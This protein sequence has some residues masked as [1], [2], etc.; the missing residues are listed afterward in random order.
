LDIGEAIGRIEKAD[1]DFNLKTFMPDDVHWNVDVRKERI[2]GYTR[3]AYAVKRE[4]IEAELAKLMR[5]AIKTKDAQK[6]A[7]KER[8]V[9]E[10]EELPYKEREL[11]EAVSKKPFEDIETLSE[12]LEVS[13]DKIQP[14]LDSLKEKGLVDTAKSIDKDKQTLLPTQKGARAV[15]APQPEGRGGP[16]HKYLQNLIKK[17]AESLGYRVIIEKPVEQ[18]KVD[19]ALE[20]DDKSI[21]CEITVTTP[22]EYE[23]GNIEKCLAFGFQQVVLISLDRKN[24]E[25]IKTLADE[26]I[27][28]EDQERLL[29]F[30][31]EEFF[32]YLEKEKIE[33]MTK[34]ETIHGYKV[35]V[36]H[37]Y[38][39]KTEK[40]TKQEAISKVILQAMKRMKG[41]K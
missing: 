32:A 40:K 23:L 2:V 9:K 21:A 33:S 17:Y 26:K 39:S 28:S 27:G 5:P 36:R 15:K 31:P 29:F 16:Q 37:T 30:I 14:T 11:L 25:K 3:K 10:P 41:K 18:G 1:C 20:K 12:K 38:I 35:R 8:P 19:L 13:E 24:L 4:A 7:I 22:P 6:A 34:E